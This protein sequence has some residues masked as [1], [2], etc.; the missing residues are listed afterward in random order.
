MGVGLA[1]RLRVVVDVWFWMQPSD[2][3]S[4]RNGKCA[5]C[6]VQVSGEKAGLVCGGLAQRVMKL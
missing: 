1:D 2:A 3:C 4:V 6:G 5:S